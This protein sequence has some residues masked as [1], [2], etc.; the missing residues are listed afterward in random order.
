MIRKGSFAH[1]YQNS[2]SKTKEFEEF[3]STLYSQTEQLC[4]NKMQEFMIIWGDYNQSQDNQ[5]AKMHL[6]QCFPFL[7]D[8][9]YQ[10]Q[11]SQIFRFITIN[12]SEKNIL[13]LMSGQFAYQQYDGTSNLEWLND[14]IRKQEL[15]S[16]SI[17]IFTSLKFILQNGLSI[18]ILQKQFKYVTQLA[19]QYQNLIQSFDKMIYN[20]IHISFVQNKNLDY[21]FGSQVNLVLN[22]FQCHNSLQIPQINYENEFYKWKKI[23]QYS[24]HADIQSPLSLYLNE[25]DIKSMYK[26]F[27][28]CSIKNQQECSYQEKVQN[29][30]NLYTKESVLYK[31]IN[32]SMNTM[33]FKIY[34]YLNTVYQLFS[35]SL[36]EYQDG[37][38]ITKVVLYRGCAIQKY[39]YDKLYEE[40]LY[41]QNNGTTTFICFPQ[42]LSTSLLKEK[43]QQ[44]MSLKIDQI[45]QQ[46]INRS[47]ITQVKSNENEKLLKSIGFDDQYKLLIKIDA[48]FDD[49]NKFKPKYI[50]KLSS[51]QDEHEFLFQPFQSFR[52]DYMQKA[53]AVNGSNMQMTLFYVC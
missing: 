30:L 33:N 31:F 9:I 13:F 19:V 17:I 43:A 8:R 16:K 48:K 18:E 29:I 44:I 21:F 20:R 3:T 39:Q 11:D 7:K 50:S 40:Y 27:K 14:K 6:I 38:K 22:L 4:E 2:N 52:I 47:K 37:Q 1:I 10:F 32:L 36:Y 46:Q 23:C 28:S 5:M 12:L 34:K 15:H 49:K 42:F 24:K 41:N 35:R 26:I 51:F 45:K 25:S 53:N